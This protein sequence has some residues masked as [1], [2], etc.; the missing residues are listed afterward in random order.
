MSGDG[1]RS[2]GL[3]PQATAPILDSTRQRV[4]H[5]E[6]RHRQQFGLTLGEPLA[7]RRTLALG[8]MSIATAVEGN[9]GMT[10]RRVLAARDM[11]SER[12]CSA[13]L[14]G[15]HHLQLAEAHTGAIGL[16]PSG[17]VVAEDIRNFQS[18]TEHE[19][20]VLLRWLV[21]LALLAQLIE[22]AHHLG[23]QVGGDACV[24]R[25]RIEPLVA[26]QSLYH[27]DIEF[28]LEQM[29]RKGVP[30]AV[31]CCA[32]S[33]LGGIGSRMEE[34]VE[35]SGRQRVDRR[36]PWKQPTLRSRRLPPLPQHVE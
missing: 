19:R 23:D 31:Q 2:V 14:D 11:T 32:L 6:I 26:E 9:D 22:W 20:R 30:Q 27:P 3:W 12:R 7:C 36:P 28:A 17:T 35:L 33:D 10:A 5:V 4:D 21:L 16:T 15:R 13:A 1:K 29:S 34:A 8:T 18:W 25:R 24:V